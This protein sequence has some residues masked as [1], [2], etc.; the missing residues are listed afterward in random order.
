MENSLFYTYGVPE[1]IVSDNGSQFRSQQFKSLL[2]RFNVN[3]MFTAVHAPQ[4]NASE[5]V[6]RS[7]LAAIKSYI[8]SNQKNWD[9][10]LSSIACALRSTIHS[11]IGTSPYY[12]VFGQHMVTNGSTYPLLRQL[13]MLE[14]RTVRFDKSDS[15]A[16]MGDRS[17][18]ITQNQFARN[19]RAYNL[20]SK[21]VSYDVGQEVFRRN[22]KQS[23]FAHGYN[24][25]LAPTFLKSRIRRKLGNSNYEL[26]D[27][28]GNFIGVYHAKDIRQ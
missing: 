25:K 4:A 7:I 19:Q 12:L 11:A 15:L 16:I 17:K 23:N 9:Q 26:E 10:M 22:F 21:N 1:T 28:Q 20:R 8:D 27:L 13:N 2:T 14:D 6:N 24:S 3:H 5:R 18:R